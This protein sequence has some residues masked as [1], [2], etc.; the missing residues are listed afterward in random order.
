MRVVGY[1]RTSRHNGEGF[2]AAAQESGL[3]SWC[4]ERGH[5]L[6]T[7]LTD[8]GVDGSVAPQER[9]ALAEAL[10]L[11]RDG[12]AAALVVRDI[13][14][15]ARQLHVQEAALALVWQADG[16]VFTVGEGEVPCD[17]PDDPYRRFIRQVL[18]ATAELEKSLALARMR[19]GR[20]EKA[21]QGRYVGGSRLHRRYGYELVDL[22]DGRRRYEPIPDEQ[23][24]IA[25]M[26][27]LRE[28]GLTLAAVAQHLDD[29][30][31]PAPGGGR[32]SA[33]TV[34]RILKRESALA[35]S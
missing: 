28:S 24:V 34:H 1:V 19:R 32:W 5:E 27:E 26:R 14:R 11:V 17:D 10:A 33:P 9:P 31:V 30:G 2:G 21:R 4:E 12:E 22:P 35:R 8:Q 29:G 18:G 20:R 13:D 6:V 3:R 23:S 7:V 16:H 25:R 15:L